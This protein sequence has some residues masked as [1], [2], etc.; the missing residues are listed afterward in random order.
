MVVR[1]INLLIMATLLLSAAGIGY[2]SLPF[3]M[4]GHTVTDRFDIKIDRLHR[5]LIGLGIGVCLLLFYDVFFRKRFRQSK[6]NTNEQT[7][8]RRS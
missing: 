2:V 1:K 3:D 5:T 6:E 7:G 4:I 8:Q